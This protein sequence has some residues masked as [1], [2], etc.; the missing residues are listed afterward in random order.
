MWTCPKCERNF[1]TANQSHSC[2]DVSL[3]DLFSG[4]PEELLLTFDRLLSELVNWEEVSVGTSK[5]AVIFTNRKAWLIVRPMSKELDLKFYNDEA[6]SSG[7]IKKITEYRGKYA[8]HI[9]IREESELSNSLYKL[10]WVGY[11]YALR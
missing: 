1:K 7:L 6:L 3:D 10:L 11:K 2:V 4:K 5:N 8:H 9:R